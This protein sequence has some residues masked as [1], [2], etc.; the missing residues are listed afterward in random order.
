MPGL[1]KN[2][3]GLPRLLSEAGIIHF[4]PLILAAV[5]LIAFLMVANTADFKNKLFSVLFPKQISHAISEPIQ[6]P[7]ATAYWKFDA[8][9]GANASNSGSCG[10]GCDATLNNMPAYPSG[11]TN[12]GKS[13]N[14][15]SFDGFDDY[16]DTGSSSALATDGSL[17]VSAWFKTS[18][19]NNGFII[20]RNGNSTI[21]YR[22]FVNSFNTTRGK[23]GKV[24]TELWFTD[25]I[26]PTLTSNKYVTDGNWHHAALVYDAFSKTIS[27][28]VD[29][30]L[31]AGPTPTGRNGSLADPSNRTFIGAWGGVDKPA[32]RYFGG[33]ID[34]IKLYKTALVADQISQEFS[35]PG[36][37]PVALP[38][39][40]AYW[41]LDE[42]DGT[43][44]KN[45]GS[46]GSS[47]NGTLIN[48]KPYSSGWTFGKYG[49]ALAYDGVD[50]Y[51]VAS[52]DALATNSNL[53]VS[54]WFKTTSSNNGFIID[55]N[56]DTTI[57]YRLFTNA[58]TASSGRIDGSANKLSGNLWFSDGIT[59]ILTSQTNVT[60]G[61]WHN[62]ALV[63]DS[64]SKTISLYVDGKLEAG[65]TPTGKTG[66]LVD[67]KNKTFI[68]AWANND[69]PGGH[70]FNGT[71]D[72]VKI[73][74]TVLTSGQILANLINTNP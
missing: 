44:T 1:I 19:T 25:G 48:V 24:S 3:K 45:E 58:F 2:Q 42:G 66:Y 9:G 70:Y 31:E 4:L 64:S 54:A 8:G 37:T 6:L 22:L 21:N 39:P 10:T 50:D 60:D 59:P 68:G 7:P 14:A 5:G 35:S 55:R 27:L 15:V 47:L 69:R 17:T 52:N 65:P 41:R 61:N 73:Y 29:G 56:G 32:G 12:S 62:G 51:V 74:N 43:T 13:G 53:T 49:S 67:T 23:Q 20:D 26:S 40:I 11:W 16:I 63:Y 46:E 72:E 36:T 33:I 57:N 34:D 71:I 30:S 38:A 28:Y 18:S